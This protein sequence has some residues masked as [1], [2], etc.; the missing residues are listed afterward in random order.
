[1]NLKPLALALLC[2]LV[3]EQ[4]TVCVHRGG[5]GTRN[6]SLREVR[7]SR[8]EVKEKLRFAWRESARLSSDRPF[9]S[10]LPACPRRAVRT[11]GG[12]F[13]RELVGKTVAFAPADRLPRADFRV[14]TYA[15]RIGDIQAEALA[16]RR[17]AER[18]GVR[19]A[20]TLVRVRSEA[21][22]ELVEGD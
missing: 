11:L 15:R 12:S 2:V 1:M 21:E 18:L 13:P 9:D 16:D 20:P 8:E 3:M 17:L 7:R 22:L 4:E 10:G 19:C 5:G 6:V 14:A